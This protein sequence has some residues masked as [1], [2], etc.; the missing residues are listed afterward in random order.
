MTPDPERT[1]QKVFTPRLIIG[2]AL[3]VLGG[4]LTLDSL[5]LVFLPHHFFISLWPLILIGI[6]LM[7]LRQRPERTTGAYVLIT[8]GCIF[9]LG[10]LGQGSLEDLIGPLILVAVGIFVVLRALK[11]HRGDQL[12]LRGSQD[13]LQGTAILSGFKQRVTSSAFKG[14]E[15]TAILGGFQIDLRSACMEQESVRLDIFALF[16]G[17]EIR[18][19]EGWNI[20]TQATAIAGGIDNKVVPTPTCDTP[21]PRLLI[22]GIVL[23]GGVEIKS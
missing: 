16:G 12:E 10:S 5:K 21:Q 8:L 13:F 19:P 11:R 15:L 7:K 22:T 17:G 18:V 14:G 3:V 9:L 20:V 1:P 23:F 4:L 6:G 2:I